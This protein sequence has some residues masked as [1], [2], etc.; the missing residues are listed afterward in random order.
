MGG[1]RGNGLRRNAEATGGGGSAGRL[2]TAATGWEACDRD[3]HPTVWGELGE[4]F[5][6]DF[7]VDVGEA[8][9]SALGTV[10][11]FGVV[12]AE[13][14]KEGGVEVVDVDFVLHGVEAEFVGF[15]EGGTALDAAAGEPHGEGVG[16]VVAAVVAALDHGGAAEFAAPDDEGVLE[17]AALFEILNEGGA[18]LIDVLAVLLQPADE[19]AVLVPG[20]VEKF[21][22]ADAA[23]DESSGEE[24]VV[25]E[26]GF[27]GGGTVELLDVFGFAGDVGDFGGDVLHAEGH[28]EGVDAALDF[29][30]ADRVEAFLVEAVDGVDGGALGVAGDAFGIGEVEDGIA[31]GAELD[32]F[33]N[34][35]EEAGAPVGGAAGGALLAGG[36]DHEGGEVVGFRSEGVGDPGAEGGAAELLGA[37]GEEDLGGGVVEGLG[38][39]GADE[40]DVVGL[41]ADVGED[42]G[43]LDAGLAVFLE[44]ELGAEEGVFGIDEGGAVVL[45]E[46]GGGLGAVEAGEVGFVVE[47]V[48]VAGGAAHEEE[49]DVLGFGGL[50][51]GLGGEGIGEVGG[52]G[53]PGEEGGEGDGAEAEAAVL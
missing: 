22:E 43:H 6:D 3:G 30:V 52:V 7:A 23:F 33:V 10:G 38:V 5:L 50:W 27:A 47:E 29:G 34:G 39:H 21:D 26:G 48:E 19:V 24:A 49:D 18:G 42:F 1:G 13:E 8:E 46:F 45:E 51:G 16:V 11:E 36:H 37:G 15:A 31:G 32:A 44:L 14:V 53:F 9:V 2:E 28:F 41:R 4:D 25:G 35:G 17:E 12:E 20:F 40:G